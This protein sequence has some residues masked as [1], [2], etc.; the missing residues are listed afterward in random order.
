MLDKWKSIH[1][2][3]NKSSSAETSGK[4]GVKAYCEK[5]YYWLD[6]IF[7]EEGDS[8]HF[9]ADRVYAKYISVAL[10]HENTPFVKGCDTTVEM[11]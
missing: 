5:D 4:S 11:N 6:A 7:C 10:E 3:N 9:A 1:S 8:V 2:A